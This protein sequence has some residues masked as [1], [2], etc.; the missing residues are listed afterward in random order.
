M[1][2]PFFYFRLGLTKGILLSI[3]VFIAN[4]SS[5]TQGLTAP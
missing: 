5:Q 3:L 2:G 1:V 4:T